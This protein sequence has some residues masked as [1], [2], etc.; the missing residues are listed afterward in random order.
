MLYE[1]CAMPFS[2]IENGTTIFTSLESIRRIAY[3]EK[4]KG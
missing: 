4:K 3:A 1:V 2:L